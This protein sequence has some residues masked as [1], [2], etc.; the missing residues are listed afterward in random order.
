MSGGKIRTVVMQSQ[1]LFIKSNSDFLFVCDAGARVSEE[2]IF[3]FNIEELCDGNI[4]D[5]QLWRRG[6]CV[7]DWQLVEVNQ[8]CLITSGACGPDDAADVIIHRFWND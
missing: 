8:T 4:P 1:F 6:L 2:S 7:G 3:I 5:G